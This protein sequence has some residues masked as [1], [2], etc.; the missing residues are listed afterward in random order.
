MSLLAVIKCRLC[1]LVPSLNP[2]LVLENSFVNFSNPR[3]SQGFHAI[4]G[5]AAWS[6]LHD[7]LWTLFWQWRSHSHTNGNCDCFNCHF[8]ILTW[9]LGPQWK[10]PVWVTH[11]RFLISPS[12]RHD[13]IPSAL[14]AITTT[15]APYCG[16]VVQS[17][18]LLAARHQCSSELKNKMIFHKQFAKF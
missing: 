12:S 1:A 2:G 6:L 4:G 15:R 10:P 11:L 5:L 8:K 16:K 3:T 9:G 7:L 13:G 17:L 14:Q 18:R